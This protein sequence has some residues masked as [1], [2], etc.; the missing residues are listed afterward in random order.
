MLKEIRLFK[1]KS[2]TKKEYDSIISIVKSLNKPIFVAGKNF[3]YVRI[4]NRNK[5]CQR[6]QI[7]YAFEGRGFSTCIG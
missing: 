2:E 3:T 4:S 7:Y 6:N 5:K 1:F